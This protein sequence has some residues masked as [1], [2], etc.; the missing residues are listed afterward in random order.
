MAKPAS[1][2]DK[3]DFTIRLDRADPPLINLI[4]IDSPGLSASMGIAQSRRFVRYCRVQF[5][6]RGTMLTQ[7]RTT[8]AALAAVLLIS[9]LAACSPVEA[10]VRETEAEAV[11][12]VVCQSL[13]LQTGS[14]SADYIQLW[15]GS[16]KLLQES[17]EVVQRTA[18]VILGAIAP[19]PEPEPET[20]VASQDS[21]TVTPPPSVVTEVAEAVPF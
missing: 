8:P 11:A 16:A 15:N 5:G 13:G 17:L 19:K 9:L 3:S 14:A 21:A 18:S 1:A 20:P 2:E 7:T 4:G 10:P 6:I 12:F